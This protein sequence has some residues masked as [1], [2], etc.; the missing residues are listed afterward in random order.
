MGQDSNGGLGAMTPNDIQ[1]GVAILE[2]V[3]PVAIVAFVGGVLWGIFRD[4]C[5]LCGK[6]IWL[7][8]VKVRKRLLS[9]HDGEYYLVGEF[10]PFHRGCYSQKIKATGIIP[11]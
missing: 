4:E 10:T 5:A 7:R 6:T 2:A 8:S 1:T 9:L 3:I 11:Q